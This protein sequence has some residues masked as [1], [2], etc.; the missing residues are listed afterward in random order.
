MR[1]LHTSDWHI[2]RTF[3]QHTTLLALRAVFTSLV[4]V[5]GDRGVDVVVVSGDIFD[6]STPSGEAVEL[7]DEVL[8]NISRAGA[9]VILTSGNHDSPAR[10]GAKAAFAREAG[11]HVITRPGQITDPVVLTDDHGPVRF[12]GIPFLEPARL[13]HLWGESTPMRSQQDAIAY[14]MELIRADLAHH[15][16]PGR[17]VVLA[18]TF[19]QGAETASADSERD[20]LGGVDKV[21]IPTFAGVDY[22]AL[23][24]IHGRAV[25]AP[26]VR[27]SG[28]PLHYS[29]SEQDK[30]RGAWLVDLDADGLAG[31]EWV[32]VVVP[33]PLTTLTGTLADLITSPAHDRFTEHWVS[34]ILTDQTRPTDAMRTLQQRY[35]YCAHLE[36]RPAERAD[37][38]TEGYATL[39]RGRTDHEIV[40]TFLARVRNGQGPSGVERELLREVIGAHADAEVSR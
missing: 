32:N 23:G 3:H 24:H 38:P 20:I 33:R 19:A 16:Q 37:Q 14:A 34:A 22:A 9:E 30:P 5:V 36:H 28:A 1:L 2:G 29:F 17:A 11:V 18:H 12:Y 13:R 10:L 26:A 21:S 4:E 27:Y 31:V 7:L 8:M 15:E 39:V 40:D 35:P 6:S 25:L